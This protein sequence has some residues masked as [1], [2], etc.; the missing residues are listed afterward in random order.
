MKSEMHEGSAL[1]VILEELKINKSQ[2]TKWLNLS[3]G[4]FQKWRD[5]K[6]N[7]LDVRMLQLIRGWIKHN[8]GVDIRAKFPRIP[9]QM[10]DI[11]L[12]EDKPTIYG[13]PDRVVALKNREIDRL[14]NENMNLK[15]R[16]N[17]VYEKLFQE[18]F[19]KMQDHFDT[20]N[21]LMKLLLDKHVK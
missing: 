18:H 21:K 4:I 9:E 2:L 1:W 11:S 14:Q 3:N 13:E 10:I 16:L 7:H 17:D 5:M 8:Y 19:K 15:E 12:I 20:Q 6:D